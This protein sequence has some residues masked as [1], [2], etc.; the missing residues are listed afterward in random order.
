MPGTIRKPASRHVMKDFG[1][2]RFERRACRPST[3]LAEDIFRGCLDNWWCPLFR[4]ACPACGTPSAGSSAN[5][6]GAPCPPRP[7]RSP[8]REQAAAVTAPDRRRPKV[9]TRTPPVAAFTGLQPAA[10]GSAW[11]LR[12]ALVSPWG[13]QRGGTPRTPRNAWRERREMTWC[14][15]RSGGASARAVTCRSSPVLPRTGRPRTGTGE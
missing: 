1:G 5:A 2:V 8:R 10:S 9:P 11:T 12:G 3:Y 15:V 4:A 14:S 13:V 7:P 6:G